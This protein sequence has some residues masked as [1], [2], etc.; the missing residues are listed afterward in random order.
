MPPRKKPA[1]KGAAGGPQKQTSVVPDS[2]HVVFTNDKG[3]SKKV[4]R[5]DEPQAP[6][7]P[8]ARKVIGG[9]SWTGKL[10]VNLLQEQCQRQKWNK[11]DYSIRKMPDA[12]GGNFRSFVTLSMTHPKTG[13]TT[14]IPPFRLPKSHEH[15]GDQPTALEARHFAAAYALFRISSMKNIHMTLPPQYRDL[16]KGL[17]AQ[18][19]QEDVD[20]GRGWKYDADPFAAEAKRQDILADIE[21]RRE[22]KVKAE[23]KATSLDLVLP[24]GN[25]GASKKNWSQAP[26]IDLG[27]RIRAEI[28]DLIRTHSVWNPYEIPVS[29]EQHASMLRQLSTLGF[30]QNHIQEALGYCKDRDEVLAWLLIHVPE[31]DLPP[32]SFPQG[33]NAGVSL[34]SGDLAKEAK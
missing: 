14:K 17:F 30:R 27:Q 23:V 22:D 26:R 6:P 16:W 11:P 2:D 33:Y 13:D 8:D 21:K 1:G 31:D 29:D 18:L 20:E 7:R 3:S 9:A 5:K 15:L 25:S 12:E 19:K 10:P 24:G 4:E 32:W 28:E 34:A